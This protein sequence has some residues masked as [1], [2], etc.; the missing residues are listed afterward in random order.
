MPKLRRRLETRSII[1]LSTAALIACGTAPGPKSPNTEP[2]AAA[3]TRPLPL[4]PAAGS[5]AHEPKPAET[6]PFHLLAESQYSLSVHPLGERV[7]VSGAPLL[8]TLDGTELR[9]DEA[10]SKGLTD[11]LGPLSAVTAAIGVFPDAAWLSLST[12]NGRTGFGL[13]YRWQ[14]DEWKRV[15]PISSQIDLGVFEWTAG[16]LL[17]FKISGA[18]FGP[19]GFEVVRGKAAPLPR[20]K[21]MP[22]AVDPYCPNGFEPSQFRAFTSGEVFLLGPSCADGES[23]V[24]QR[25]AAGSMVAIAET[26]PDSPSEKEHGSPGVLFAPSASDV[27]L[28]MNSQHAGAYLSHFDGKQWIAEPA[29]SKHEMVAASALADGSLWAIT[30]EKR[31]IPTGAHVTE[32]KM[33]TELWSRAPGGSWQT[34]EMPSVAAQPGV[35]WTAIDVVA[36]APGDVW[37][38]ARFCPGKSSFR[39]YDGETLVSEV[40]CHFALFRTIAA[41]KPLT[42]FP[43]PE[44]VDANRFSIRRAL[45]LVGECL[46][47][48]FVVLYR[49]GRNAP[50]NFDYPATRAALKGHTELEEGGLAFVESEEDGR[51]YFGAL[52][53]DP[54][55]GRQ[56]AA[57]IE[58]GVPGSHP[59]VLCGSPEVRRML[60]I[61]LAS[62]NITRIVGPDGSPQ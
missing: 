36:R 46:S 10:A 55:T 35:H 2:A 24:V 53:R 48:V 4:P 18:P 41:T 50:P 61:D 51:R 45:P 60:Y 38:T 40:D 59:S 26:L 15:G 52:V 14:A 12:S 44:D 54:T 6:S 39:S 21:R 29:P 25:W 11:M 43:A 62:G 32:E 31:R 30:S 33:V 20:I 57:L 13:R 9:I 23:P 7:F 3:P 56:L 34:V 37:I 22:A 49:L 58:K 1:L 16:R 28:A 42:T 17:S 5:T 8:A 27:W 47:N 19:Q